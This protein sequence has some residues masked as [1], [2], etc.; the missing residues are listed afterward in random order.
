LA[1]QTAH[2]FNAAYH[3][4]S[5]AMIWTLFLLAQHPR[6]M[7]AVCDELDEVLHAEVVTPDELPRL[8]L[9]ER[10]LKESMRL[11]PPVVYYPRTATRTME[12]AGRAWPAGTIVVGS[13]YLTQ[14]MAELFPEP[15][16]FLPDR[17]LKASVSPYAYFPFGGGPRM[18]I[19]GPFSYMVMK[20]ALSMILQRYRLTVVPGV[21]IER[22]G[23]FTMGP[24][25]GIPLIV[26][27]QDRRFG[28]SEVYGTIHEMVEMPTPTLR[29]TV[30]A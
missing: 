9:L 27:K 21:R 20:T 5:Y 29:T 6:V 12:M 18:C 13:M 30:A 7:T 26:A 11:L 15:D 3:T 10:A 25:S 24:R 19:G 8:T 22:K 4:T 16:R 23:T 28:T 17:W 14:H 1:G 2:L